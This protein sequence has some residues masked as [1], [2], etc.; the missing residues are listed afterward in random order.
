MRSVCRF[1]DVEVGGVKRVELEGCPR[2]LAVFNLDG[3]IYVTDDRC[4]HAEASLSEGR[5]EGDVV[6]C[7]FHRGSF[8]I[9]SGD[10]RSRPPKVPLR[11]YEVQIVGDEVLIDD[12]AVFA[13]DEAVA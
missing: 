4:T 7:P 11:T 6:H 5:I 13:D 2:A 9:P 12:S 10:V 1:G 8:H 3:T